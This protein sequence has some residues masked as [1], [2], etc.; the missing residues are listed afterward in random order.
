[1]HST[2]RHFSCLCFGHC[3]SVT[4]F[5][6]LESPRAPWGYSFRWFEEVTPCWR[7]LNIERPK[8][9]KQITCGQPGSFTCEHC[10]ED[11]FQNC[12]FFFIFLNFYGSRTMGSCV[13]KEFFRFEFLGLW[14]QE[15]HIFE[16]IKFWSFLHK[17]VGIL[18]SINI[19]CRICFD[20]V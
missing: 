11:K 9:Q 5:Q 17:V 16:I 13:S 4:V 20:K 6:S 12:I 14:G 7:P 3:A 8:Q 18:E 1:M 15:V 10:S 19:W 2:H